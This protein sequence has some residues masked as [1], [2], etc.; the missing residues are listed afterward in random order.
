MSPAIRTSA[1]L[2]VATCAAVALVVVD[3]VVESNYANTH[4]KTYSIGDY[5][6]KIPERYVFNYTYDHSSIALEAM[7]PDLVPNDPA[8]AKH[9]T[10]DKS[11]YIVLS[12]MLV[13][14]ISKQLGGIYEDPM[15]EKKPGPFGLIEYPDTP[16]SIGS[17][18]YAKKLDNGQLYAIF[19]LK[20][21][22][23]KSARFSIVCS[24]S[25]PLSAGISLRY[26]FQR[27]QLKDW[28]Q[29]HTSVLALISSF[30]T[31]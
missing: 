3:Q 24:F 25:A 11:I 27:S 21:T 17:D 13:P 30:Q 29:I 15:A 6:F 23:P 1:V 12:T 10:C 7:L 4:P 26:K 22:G 20:P 18:V 5:K 9:N 14:P 8:C 31:K 19:C 16:I 28:E 2:L